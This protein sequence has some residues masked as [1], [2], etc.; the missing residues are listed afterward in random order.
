MR[1]TLFAQLIAVML[2]TTSIVLL[3]L[4]PGPG[5]DRGVVDR[6]TGQV[7]SSSGHAMEKVVGSGD[8]GIALDSLLAWPLEALRDPEVA[9]VLRHLQAEQSVSAERLDAEQVLAV[10]AM[11]IVEL[12]RL[13]QIAAGDAVLAHS[14]ERLFLFENGAAHSLGIDA[15]AALLAA[16]LRNGDPPTAA[17]MMAMA[18]AFHGHGR[19]R[20]RDRWLRR[21]VL[22]DPESAE[23]RLATADFWI[24]DVRLV[25]AAAILRDVTPGAGIAVAYWQ[26]AAQVMRWLGLLEFEIQALRELALL[27]PVDDVLRRL[28]QVQR[29]NL[30]MTEAAETQLQYATQHGAPAEMLA[31]AAALL[32]V[33]ARERGLEVLGDLSKREATSEAAR[34]S[35]AAVLEHDQRYDL[36]TEQRVAIAKATGELEDRRALAIL[37]RRQQRLSELCDLILADP[38]LF[39]DDPLAIVHMLVSANREAD[40]KKLLARWA[41]QS[42]RPARFF[43]LLSWYQDAEVAGLGKLAADAASR[44]AESEVSAALDGVAAASELRGGK[45]FQA[46]AA[47]QTLGRRFPNHALVQAAR[48]AHIESMPVPADALRHA[49]RLLAERPTDLAVVRLMVACAERA[50]DLGAERRAR[51]VWHALQPSFHANTLALAQLCDQAKDVAAALLLWRELVAGGLRSVRGDLI[52]ALVR[53]GD[54]DAVTQLTAKWRGEGVQPLLLIADELFANNHTVRALT[55]YEEVVRIDAAHPLANQ[56]AGLVHAWHARPQQAI[57]YLEQALSMAVADQESTT[58]HLAECYWSVERTSDAVE[59][60]REVLA[61]EARP[62]DA[63][64][65]RLRRLRALQRTGQVDAAI[66][67]HHQLLQADPHQ[68]PVLL[69]LTDTLFDEAR[70]KEL[71]EVLRR[72][73]ELPETV[74]PHGLQHRRLLRMQANYLLAIGDYG[75]AEHR[76]LDL[77]RRGALTASELGDRGKVQ[78][79]RGAFGDALASYQRW[80]AMNASGNAAA[81][82]QRVADRLATHVGM[83]ASHT[84]VGDDAATVAGINMATTWRERTRLQAFVGYGSF[85]GRSQAVAGG[86]ADVD[87]DTALLDLGFSHRYGTGHDQFGAGVRLHPGASGSR[88]VGLW[89]EHTLQRDDSPWSLSVRGY[90]DELWTDPTAAAGLEGRRTGIDISGYRDL[91]DRMWISTEGSYRRLE[92]R[93]PLQSATRDHSVAGGV[94]FG[95]RWTSASIAVADP[96]RAH[97]APAGPLSPYLGE[98]IASVGGMHVATWLGYQTEHLLGDESLTAILPLSGRFN[99]VYGAARLD[100]CL[101]TGLGA[102]IEALVGTD[103]EQDAATWQATSALTFRSATTVAQSLEFTARVGFGDAMG[104]AT[105]DGKTMFASLTGLVRW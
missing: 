49:Q 63:L 53:A 99:V 74:L 44:V 43:R 48:M 15:R 73:L 64:E 29:A 46:N 16:K 33:G 45:V 98:S 102:S 38:D 75:E 27:D 13:L 31:A 30:R 95:G 2:S 54:L 78:E 86:T 69:S 65:R 42:E 60:F 47:L 11:P 35:L 94:Q 90:L 40:A 70:H 104:R 6:H 61:L 87:T 76:W 22:V 79:L 59:K 1:M 91:G 41:R 4:L 37:L 83:Q 17:T 80:T 23:L 51:E 82:T 32:S 72:A 10:H 7:F 36:A 68:V 93:A 92:A 57:P 96:F 28:T 58:F 25:E 56:R 18:R 21:A 62:T 39:D 103:L 34:R 12:L 14:T 97:R 81:V 88:D 77:E 67:G 3:L 89:A 24:A 84:K 105:F 55:L 52:A 50:G 85:A 8:A 26:R 66:A 5:V 9:T 71:G 101:A 20:A 100:R 19:T